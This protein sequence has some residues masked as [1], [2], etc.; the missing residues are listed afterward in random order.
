MRCSCERVAVTI[1][2]WPGI[3]ALAAMDGVEDATVAPVTDADAGEATRATAGV[4]ARGVAVMATPRRGG[5]VEASA[6]RSVSTSST[7]ASKARRR[8][9]ERS[10]RGQR[11]GWWTRKADGIVGT[12]IAG[13][14]GRVGMRSERAP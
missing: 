1:V 3:G 5:G 2:P 9:G 12:W 4:G 13:S 10:G 11:E 6:T 7:L 14:V 8:Q